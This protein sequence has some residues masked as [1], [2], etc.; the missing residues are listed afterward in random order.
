MSDTRGQLL[1]VVHTWLIEVARWSDE[2]APAAARAMLDAYDHEQA[3]RI[4]EHCRATSGPCGCPGAD[5]ID[6][7]VSK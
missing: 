5:L 1:R 6:P 2:K 3:E 7:E 4:R